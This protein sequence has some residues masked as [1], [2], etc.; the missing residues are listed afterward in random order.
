[1]R[2]G[3]SEVIAWKGVGDGVEAFVRCADDGGDLAQRG[4][5]GEHPLPDNGVLSNQLPA[6]V[7][8]RSGLIEDRVRDR[9]LANV[10]ELGSLLESVNGVPRQAQPLADRE[11]QLRD[12]GDV[13]S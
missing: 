9:H 4:R 2:Y 8:E 3:R 5:G 12:F 1:V 10:V 13:G 6:L 7:V 11:R